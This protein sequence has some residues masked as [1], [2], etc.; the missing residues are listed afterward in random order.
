M[1]FFFLIANVTKSH[2]INLT[3][4]RSNLNT[5]KRENQ[6]RDTDP[7]SREIDESKVLYHWTITVL[8][9]DGCSIARPRLMCK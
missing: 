3:D 8:W 6:Y 7:E 9:L 5:S 2:N 1:N 4:V